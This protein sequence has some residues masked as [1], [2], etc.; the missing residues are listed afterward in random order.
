MYVVLTIEAV[1]TLKVI[2]SEVVLI[3]ERAY[4]RERTVNVLHFTL[5]SQSTEEE[6]A[7]E[8]RALMQ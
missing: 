8:S 6:K 5:S 1:L 4:N 2:G 7:A 3:I